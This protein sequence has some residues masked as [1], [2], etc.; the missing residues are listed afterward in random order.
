MRRPVVPLVCPRHPVVYK[1][2]PHGLPR[3]A[4]VVRA[5]HHLAEPPAR[6][7]RIQPVRVHGR[8]LHVINLPSAKMR[9]AHIPL[10]A[11]PVRC[12]NECTLPCTY[13]NPY[14]THPCL[15]YDCLLRPPILSFPQRL[16]CWQDHFRNP[17]Q[18]SYPC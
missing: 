13:Q 6:L 11:I 3:L 5:L 8:T 16:S 12:Q 9:P 17:C 4:P 1:L 7:R 10:L 15:L 14:S 2:V 18:S